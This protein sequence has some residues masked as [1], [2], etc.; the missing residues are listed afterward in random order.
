M[1]PSDESRYAPERSAS[2]KT[3][4]STR[5][6]GPSVLPPMGGIRT[7]STDTNVPT[8]GLGVLQAVRA[9]RPSR[10][11]SRCRM[12]GSVDEA[13]PR[14]RFAAE[15]ID[16]RRTRARRGAHAQHVGQRAD[17]PGNEL[18]LGAGVNGE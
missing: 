7:S 18:V 11:R 5:S 12:L 17:Q 10:G 1:V 15:E 16:A 2:W 13:E 6:P 9:Q 4:T 3:R 14:V 8:S